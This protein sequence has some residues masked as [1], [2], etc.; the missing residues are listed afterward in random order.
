MKQM[1]YSKG[2]K[3]LDFQEHYCFNYEVEAISEWEAISE[4]TDAV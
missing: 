4:C 1:F 3:S 2:Y